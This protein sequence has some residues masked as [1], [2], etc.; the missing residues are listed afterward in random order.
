DSQQLTD[1][2]GSVTLRVTRVDT[3]ILPLV[4]AS[5]E[6]GRLFT[7]AEIATNAPLALISDSLWRTRYG[8]D[9]SILGRQIRA[10]KDP[11]TIIGVLAPGFRFNGTS[12]LWVPLVEHADTGSA[13]DADWY[14]LAAKLKPGVS[15]QQAQ[16]EVERFG[17]NLAS[18]TPADFK[19]LSLTVQGSLVS[20]GNIAYFT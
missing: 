12:D 4:G 9:E 13:K 20:R 18:S 7:S 11:R 15:V 2:L 3:A 5:A 19:H 10:D 1:Q 17:R 14:W 16:K 6:R 8:R